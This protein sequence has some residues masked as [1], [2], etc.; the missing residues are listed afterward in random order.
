MKLDMM[1][2]NHNL[3]K[4][5]KI[6]YSIDQMSG[7]SFI[8]E[9]YLA[10]GLK[11]SRWLAYILATAWHETAFTMRPVTEYGSKEYLR[12]K[13]Y[14]PY[15]GRGYVQITHKENYEKYNIADNLDAALDPEIAAYILIQGMVKGVFTGRKLSDYFNASTDDAFNARKI[16]NGLD[17]ATRIKEYHD[18]FLGVIEMSFIV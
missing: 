13:P 18:K 8:I 12:S 11:N 3:I 1:T 9:K 10:T 5:F 2:F 17:R 16:V 14:W 6:Q 4:A 15:I 7:I